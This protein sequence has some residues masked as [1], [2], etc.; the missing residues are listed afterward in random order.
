MTSGRIVVVVVV[1]VIAAGIYFFA[2]PRPEVAL[3]SNP[4]V[5]R[6]SQ[7]VL[8]G[9]TAERRGRID[10]GMLQSQV[11]AALGE[12]SEK[13][14]TRGDTVYARWNYLYADGYLSLRLRGGRVEQIDTTFY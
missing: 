12:P 8:P 14:E 10:P 4:A 1:V 13:S 9:R 11:E 6:N 7:H 3:S 2:R 5:N